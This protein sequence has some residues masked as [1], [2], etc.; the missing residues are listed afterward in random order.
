MVPDTRMVGNMALLPLKTQFKGPAR[1]DG[2][3]ALQKHTR[4]LYVVP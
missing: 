3:A 1:G 2:K 4:Y